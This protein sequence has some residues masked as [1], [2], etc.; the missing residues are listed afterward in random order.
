MVLTIE[1]YV[2]GLKHNIPLQATLDLTISCYNSQFGKNPQ[3]SELG[4]IVSKQHAQR[5]VDMILEVEKQCY[6]LC[7]GSKQCNVEDKYIAPTILLS[8]PRDCRLMR[9]EIFGPILPVIIVK[10]RQEAI[11]FIQQQQVCSFDV[12]Y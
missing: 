1:R 11:Q 9:E 6:V 7:G 10:S 12:A 4:R 3:D 8:P 5:H 2:L